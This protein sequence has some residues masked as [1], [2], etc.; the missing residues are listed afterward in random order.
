MPTCGDFTTYCTFYILLGLPSLIS[1]LGDKL[2]REN[3]LATENT[4]IIV[5]SG[6]NQAY[7]NCVL[8]LMSEG[9]LC[10]VFKPYYFNHVMA[11]QMTRGQGA[12]L[13]G[14]I[15]DDGYPSTDWLR[16]QFESNPNIK[17]VTITNPGNPTGVSIPTEKLQEIIEI[18]R[19]YDA[20]AVFDCTYEQF[21]H[22]G[23]NSFLIDGPTSRETGFNCFSDEHVINIFSFSKGYAMAGFRVGYV[24]VNTKEDKGKDAYAQMVKV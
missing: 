4:S 13:V 3:K 16:N 1:A 12:L 22:S 24:A 11:I 5:T 7:M 20:W 14:P 18:C 17:M 15:D 23:D 10:V 9:D 21:D 19:M 6:A 2:S 8:T